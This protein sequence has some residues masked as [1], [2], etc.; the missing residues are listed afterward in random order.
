MGK[1]DAFK[2]LAEIATEALHQWVDGLSV[3]EILKNFSRE[4]LPTI[5]RLRTILLHL[6]SLHGGGGQLEQQ[7][8]SSR[9]SEEQMQ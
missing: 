1:R 5:S 7:P 4:S 6:D 2:P 8:P 9:S 3:E